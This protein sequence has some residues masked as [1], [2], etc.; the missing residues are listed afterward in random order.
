MSGTTARR[1]LVSLALC[2]PLAHA[3]ALGAQEPGAPLD[4]THLE[5]LASLAQLWGTV[6]FFNP[7]AVADGARWDSLLI[8]AI[9]SVRASRSAA[10]YAAAV[11]TML[12]G[13]GDP[14]TGLV[15][16]E[17]AGESTTKPR[18]AS[19]AWAADSVLVVTLAQHDDFDGMHDLLRSRHDTI[20]RARAV[21][22][23]LRTETPPEASAL[24]Q[25]FAY[26]GVASALARTPM[27]PPS[28]RRRMYSGWPSESGG[29][30][31][32]FAA[33]YDVD[34]ERVSPDSGAR[35]K[36]VVFLVSERSGLPRVATSLRQAGRG[37]IVLEGHSLNPTVLGRATRVPLADRLVVRVRSGE[38]VA[39]GRPLDLAPD[40]VVPTPAAGG[41]DDGLRVALAMATAPARRPMSIGGSADAVARLDGRAS[42]SAGPVYPSDAERVFA[43]LKT[44]YVAQH[45]F[46]YREL[47]GEDWNAV[48][49]RYLSRLDAARDSSEYVLTVAEMVTH[50]HDTHVGVRSPVLRAYYGAATPAV[51]VQIVAGVPVVVRVAHHSATRAAGIRVGDVILSVDGESAAS[52]RSRFARIIAHSTPQALDYVIASALLRGPDS[53]TAAVRVRGGDGQPRT[54]RLPRSVTFWDS[55]AHPREGPILRLLPGN[56]GYADLDRMPVAMVDSMFELFREARAIIFDVRGYPLGTAWSIAPRLTSRDVVAAARFRRP[57]LVSPDTNEHSVHAF[58]EPLP[59]TRKWRYLG[60]TVMLA[61]ERTVSQAEYT[62]QFFRAANGTLVVGSPTTGANGDVSYFVLPGRVAV[63]F[64]GQ[65]VRHADGSQLQRVG[66]VPD[67]R[68]RPTIAGIRAGRDEVLEKALETLGRTPA[69]VAGARSAPR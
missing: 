59:P 9:P 32:Y 30:P 38:F 42:P 69:V 39:D 66:L 67:V 8:A 27:R 62:G 7:T 40:S 51:D 16:T 2:V 52:R 22:F 49:R 17:T 34:G 37:W 60:R 23:D 31:E 18:P 54:V 4:S 50:L 21:V 48:L 46:A 35:D 65:D 24:L 13:L 25:A 10:E 5:R 63:S 36:T 43:G 6:R 58:V 45:F 28:L 44:W 61:D 20:S 64:T 14:A 12:D 11:R 26:S 57:M 68:V 19:A 33:W 55:L 15:E 56:V 1:V 47:M 3:G 53:S 29:S 41:A